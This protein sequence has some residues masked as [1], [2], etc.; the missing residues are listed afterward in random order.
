[1][2]SWAILARAVPSV[3]R[4]TPG[5]DAAAAA[6]G[7]A[8]APAAA[9]AA[10]VPPVGDAPTRRTAPGPAEFAG[11][12]AAIGR[13]IAAQRAAPGQPEIAPCHFAAAVLSAGGDPDIVAQLNSLMPVAATVS[14]DDPDLFEALGR[15]GRSRAAALLINRAPL[16]RRN[17]LAHQFRA[18]AWLA[19]ELAAQRWAAAT[20]DA[21]A[22]SDAI[23]QRVTQRAAP[24]H[25]GRSLAPGAERPQRAPVPPAPPIPADFTAGPGQCQSAADF[26]PASGPASAGALGLSAELAA[27]ANAA[28]RA[29]AIEATG[30]VSASEAASALHRVAS[31]PRAS[32]TDMSR[33]FALAAARGRPAVLAAFAAASPSLLTGQSLAVA[34]AAAGAAGRAA[35]VRW[36]AAAARPAEFSAAVRVGGVRALRAAT[37]GGC[38]CTISALL[39]AAEYS[40]AELRSDRNAPVRA[41]CD[42]G[43]AAAAVYF[44]SRAGLTR[45]DMSADG[46]ATER[47]ARARND[48]PVACWLDSRTSFADE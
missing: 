30:D 17:A 1:M 31:H 47:A 15:G 28:W 44:A 22:V 24:S 13:A 9:I 36:F 32:P 41:A 38:P 16:A 14:A 45:A 27:P 42:A 23:A 35:A 8:I 20:A 3:D 19:G 25:A 12:G 18:A 39:D 34:I 6:A 5:S 37:A 40:P 4:L 48:W 11:L 46:G 33:A 2:A 26:L 43:A 7:A 10:G 29:V 21:A